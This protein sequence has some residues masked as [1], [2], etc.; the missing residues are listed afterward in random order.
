MHCPIIIIGA[1]PAGI[2]CSLHL[3][4][5]GIEHILLES[6]QFPRDKACADILTS[7][8]IRELTLAD[9]QIPEHLIA[10]P[11]YQEIWG[12]SLRLEENQAMD[13]PY[14]GLDGNSAK[15]SCIAVKRRELDECIWQIASSKSTCSAI[16][17][18]HVT[19]LKTEGG[20]HHLKTRSGSSF[21]CNFLVLAGG[22][23]NKLASAAGFD[24]KEG[25][26]HTA[27]GLRA[28]F[29]NVGGIK[30]DRCEL[31]LK[32]GTMPGGF[33][34]A[35][36]GDGE[37]N[38]NVVL[39]KD[40]IQQKN[41]KLKDVLEDFYSHDPS[42]AV[43]FKNAIK[44]SQSMGQNLHLGTKERSRYNEAVFLCGDSGGLIDLISA[45]GIPQACLSGRLVAQA[46]SKALFEELSAQAAGKWYEHELQKEIASD[47]RLGKVLS[48]WM[49]HDWFNSLLIKSLVRIQGSGDASFLQELL[50]AD[51][52]WT[53]LKQKA[54]PLKMFG[55]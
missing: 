9:S 23:L 34:I 54:N 13:I 30:P 2:C 17:S 55:S 26:R 16:E 21:S 25:D 37:C 35:P 49:S 29:K 15:A 46:L 14:K 32:R 12:T 6:A 47:L 33:Y 8:A 39:R 50:Y 53:L 28:Y 45:N 5:L 40:L 44:V 27:L 42:L 51:D 22:S 19:R 38:V 20:T 3:S 4:R 36:L 11:S 31:I 18:M 7:K 48:P 24:F 1:G 52:P 43:R 41:L 10:L